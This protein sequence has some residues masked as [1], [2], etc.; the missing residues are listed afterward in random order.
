LHIVPGI[1]KLRKTDTTKI[2][3]KI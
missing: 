2:W 3:K 1:K